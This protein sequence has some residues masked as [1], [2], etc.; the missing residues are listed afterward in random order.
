MNLK[1]HL[2]RCQEIQL[3]S[4]VSPLAFQYRNDVLTKACSIHNQCVETRVGFE[5]ASGAEDA[6]AHVCRNLFG[7]HTESSLTITVKIVEIIP[8]YRHLQILGFK[9]VPLVTKNEHPIP[10]LLAVV[11]RGVG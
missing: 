10:L 8:S 3:C 5:Y 9:I 4:G 6:T 2:K 11:L 7:E 1:V